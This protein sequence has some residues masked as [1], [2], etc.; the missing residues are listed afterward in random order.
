[1]RQQ[2]RCDIGKLLERGKLAL[3]S[4]R[5]PVT[6]LRLRSSAMAQDILTPL[7]HDAGVYERVIPIM[8]DAVEDFSRCFGIRD[9]CR[10]NRRPKIMELVAERPRAASGERVREEEVTAESCWRC[11][12]LA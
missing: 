10:Q 4:R 3:K 5:V 9:S 11:D 8:P 7:D 1:M 2:I 12:M 6:L